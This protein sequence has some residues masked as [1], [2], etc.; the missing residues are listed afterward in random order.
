MDFGEKKVKLS[1]REM[2][3]A[4]DAFSEAAN[5]R[6]RKGNDPL[7]HLGVLATLKSMQ[8]RH[9]REF[10]VTEG[11]IL[12]SSLVESILGIVAQYADNTQEAI[13]QITNT[14]PKNEVYLPL[15]RKSNG[16]IAE[17]MT[18]EFRIACSAPVPV[19]APEADKLV[20]EFSEALRTVTADDFRAQ[21]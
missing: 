14:R 1:R 20:S 11:S 9:S 8:R 21:P 5:D 7:W 13:V 19:A 6:L 4:I 17:N 2:A 15:Q 10:F 3:V 18:L 12:R 16:V